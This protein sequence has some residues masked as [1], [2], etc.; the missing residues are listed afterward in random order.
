MSSEIGNEASMVVYGADVAPRQQHWR[1]KWFDR[2]SQNALQKFS[3][4][5]ARPLTLR[6]AH[7]LLARKMNAV[8][9]R[10]EPVNQ[11]SHRPALQELP[12]LV[13]PHVGRGSI[14]CVR[15]DSVK[16]DDDHAEGA[17]E[18]NW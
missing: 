3:F 4:L 7:E 16:V 18:G 17:F 13:Q 5:T 2:C 6:D 11:T 9:G 15:G 10:P 1:Y 12:G 14:S 8:R